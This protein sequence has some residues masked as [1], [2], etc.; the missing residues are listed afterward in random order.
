[1]LQTKPRLLI[2]TMA[3]LFVTMEFDA[4]ALTK[5]PEKPIPNEVRYSSEDARIRAK[6]M[7]EIYIAT[8]DMLHH[9]YFHQERTMVPARAMEDVFSEL[10]KLQILKPDGCR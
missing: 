6:L 7:N 3:L 8:L 5:D 4:E 1:M 9:R 10:K 2:K